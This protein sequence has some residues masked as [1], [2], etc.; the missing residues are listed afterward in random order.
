MGSNTPMIC[1]WS[2][3]V[4]TEQCRVEQDKLQKPD[5]GEPLILHE[6]TRMQEHMEPILHEQC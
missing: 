1:D 6:S 4:N 5:D 2:S 3:P